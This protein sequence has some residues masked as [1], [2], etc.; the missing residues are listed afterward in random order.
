MTTVVVVVVVAVF[1][2]AAV[3]AALS[4]ELG[5]ELELEPEPVVYVFAAELTDIG[6]EYGNKQGT[7]VKVVAEALS[8]AV[9]PVV[10]V[11]EITDS[12]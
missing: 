5:P 6:E 2:A 12:Y 7:F 1:V 11:V 8:H 4:L 10:A 9:S 3:V